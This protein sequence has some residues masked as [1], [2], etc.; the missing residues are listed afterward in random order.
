MRTTPFTLIAAAAAG[1]LLV[2]PAASAQSGIATVTVVHGIPDTVLDVWLDGALLLDD[3]EPSS[4]T[5][6]LSVPAGD[7]QIAMTAPDADDD[8]DP[9]G[10]LDVSLAADSN[11]SLVAQLTEVGDI[12]L[13]DFTND[14]SALPG[15]TARVSV[16]HVASVGAADIL[17]DGEPLVEGLEGGEEAV[18]EVPAGDHDIVVN[19]AGTDDELL[20]LPGTSLAEGTNTLVFAVGSPASGTFEALVQTI[21]GLQDAPAAVPAGNAGLVDD[22]RPVTLIVGLVALAAMMLVARRRL[23][24]GTR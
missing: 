5:E 13:V 3:F 17:A 14:V 1:L 12:E 20:A 19:A 11:V 23:D 6:P 10:S 16:R 9:V 4:L 21:T 8:S 2:A 15:G 7:H 24:A 18:A 22:G